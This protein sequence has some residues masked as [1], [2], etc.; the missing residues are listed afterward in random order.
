MAAVLENKPTNGP[1]KSLKTS[2]KAIVIIRVRDAGGSNQDGSCK[3]DK[4]CTDSRFNLKIEPIL[5]VNKM[6][7][8][9]KQK[10]GV[11]MV[12]KVLC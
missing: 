8:A 5:F 12:P 2:Q 9:Q 11:R 1:G 3:G 6:R 4:K 7:V 10:R